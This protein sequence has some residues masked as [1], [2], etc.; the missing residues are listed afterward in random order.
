[1][2][3]LSAAEFCRDLGLQE[4]ILVGDAESVVKGYI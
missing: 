3:A 2:G 1:M 4:I